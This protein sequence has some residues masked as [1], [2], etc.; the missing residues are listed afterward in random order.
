MI[1]IVQ[2]APLNHPILDVFLLG[3]VCAGSLV[4][5]LFFLR[6]WRTTRDA[7]FMA[8]TVFFAIEGANEAYTAT[9][10]HPNVGSLAVTVVRLL[11]VLGILVAILWKNL[12][13]Q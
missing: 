3:F 6:F 10:R 2:L 8:F 7:L 13:R 11:A 9:L 12:A 1:P 4:A 5:A